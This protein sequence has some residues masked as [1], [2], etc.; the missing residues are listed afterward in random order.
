MS[1]AEQRAVGLK[2]G[3]LM[4]IPL[5][6]IFI[7][8]LLL[9]DESIS[10]LDPPPRGPFTWLTKVRKQTFFLFIY[11]GPI[12]PL[13]HYQSLHWYT[14]LIQSAGRN[15]EGPLDSTYSGPFHTCTF[16]GFK[17]ACKLWLVPLILYSSTMRKIPCWALLLL[18]IHL[19][20]L[21]R[22]IFLF[23]FF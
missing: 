4:P 5:L 20:Q 6:L 1:L 13:R 14:T 22:I 23:V 12:S 15:M 17:H 8:N 2:M 10:F 9:P 18:L 16:T 19:K 21:L 7:A 11:K 3:Q